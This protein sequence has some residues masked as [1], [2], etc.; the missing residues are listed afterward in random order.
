MGRW[1]LNY[2]GLPLERNQ[3]LPFWDPVVEKVEKRLNGWSKALLSRG[4][5]TLVQSVLSTLP[6]YY[7]FLFRIPASIAKRL[8]QSMRNLLWEGVSEGKKD[9]LINWEIVFQSKKKGGL[10]VGNLRKQNEALL[11]KWLWRLQNETN[12]LWY[13]VIRSIYGMHANEWDWFHS[14]LLLVLRSVMG[15]K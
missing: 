12:A 6:T 3:E 7:L 2:L 15:K 5:L 8:K 13:M 11:R 9:H 14:L 1:P 10:G 4:R